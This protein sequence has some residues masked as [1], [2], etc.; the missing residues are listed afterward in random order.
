MQ[1]S[2][3]QC[4]AVQVAMEEPIRSQGSFI[5]ASRLYMLQV[6]RLASL[7]P[8]VSPVFSLSHL[9]SLPSSL[10]SPVSFVTSLSPIASFVDV[11]VA[12]RMYLVSLASLV[13]HVSSVLALESCVSR[14]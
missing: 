14:L 12:S 7:P 10:P 13:S 11:R 4:N 6:F 3:V 5:D 2:A 9:L 1:S 8:S